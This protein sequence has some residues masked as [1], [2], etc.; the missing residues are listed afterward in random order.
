M[1]NP[2]GRLEEGDPETMSIVLNA[3]EKV[4]EGVER[5]GKHI[6]GTTRVA[7]CSAPLA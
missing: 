3:L 6:P 7:S 5:V 2:R 4:G 1:T